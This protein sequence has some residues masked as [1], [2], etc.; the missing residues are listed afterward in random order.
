MFTNEAATT[1]NGVINN[2]IP[3]DPAVDPT[4]KADVN[5]LAEAWTNAAIRFNKSSVKA[6]DKRFNWLRSNQNSE[7]K[8]HQGINFSFDNPLLE[9]ALNGSSKR[10]TDL[11]NKDIESWARSNWSDE[12]LKNESDQVFNDPVSYTHLTLPTTCHV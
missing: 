7:K 5:G 1:S 4:T 6:V 10:F 8:S 3:I 12:R 11:N 9:K 2:H